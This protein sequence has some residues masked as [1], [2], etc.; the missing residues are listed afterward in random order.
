VYVIDD[1]NAFQQRDTIFLCH[2]TDGAFGKLADITLEQ[3]L[4]PLR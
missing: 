1:G 4:A 3:P 2:F